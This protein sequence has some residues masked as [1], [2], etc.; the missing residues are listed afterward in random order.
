MNAFRAHRAPRRKQFI[1]ALVAGPHVKLCVRE[2]QCKLDS[3]SNQGA[4]MRAVDNHVHRCK[5]R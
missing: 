3:G 2:G 5:R 1:D 4:A